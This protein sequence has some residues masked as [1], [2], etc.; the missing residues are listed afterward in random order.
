MKKIVFVSLLALGTSTLLAGCGLLPPIDLGPDPIGLK[1]QKL[2]STTLSATGTGGVSTRIVGT[3]T[4]SAS[5]TFADIDPSK[6][7]IVPSSIQLN[8]ELATGSISAACAAALNQ[9]SVAVKLTNLTLN[10]N[11]GVG[12]DHSLSV[13][14]PVVNFSINTATGA[15]SNLDLT[16]LAFTIGGANINTAKSILTT[17]P[18]P[19]NASVTTG[20][21]TTP[22]L[23]GCTVSVTFG[24]GSGSAKL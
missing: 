15:I 1:G 2:T 12:A 10:L 5:A 23:P 22:A 7:T 18:T 13:T 21:E 14:V 8:L 16:T 4:A 11:D 9:T 17:L 20:I 24:P 19:N 6:F 3:G